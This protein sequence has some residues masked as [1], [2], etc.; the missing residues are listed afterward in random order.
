MKWTSKSPDETFE[1]A[2]GFA[3]KLRT[4]SVL[5]LEGEL[6]AGKTRFVQGLA[7]GLGVPKGVYVRSPSFTIM[8]EYR[9][10][11]LNLYHFDF[12][13]LKLA[14]ELQDLGLEEYFEGGGV[15]AVEWAERFEN[16][17]PRNAI[18]LRFRVI[19]ETTREICNTTLP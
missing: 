14:Q 7:A 9:G 1:L 18:W 19:D 12:Y 8:N 15:S 10:G 13:R 6:G 4:N 17:L 5:A 3:K 2:Y 11:R 16:V